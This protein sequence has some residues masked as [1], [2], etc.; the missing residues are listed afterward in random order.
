MFKMTSSLREST[1]ED[2]LAKARSMAPSLGIT[3]VTDTTWLDAIGMPVYASIRPDA[4][5][6]TLCVNAGKGLRPMEAQVG[7]YMEAI[8]FAVAEYRNRNIE[9]IVSTPAD[10]AQQA[11]AAFDYVDLCPVLGYKIAPDAKVVCVVAEDIASGAEL[12]VPAELVFHPF[13]ENDGLRT[14]GTGTNGLCSGNS[15]DEATVH[16]L[17]ELMERD[18]TSFNLF[19]DASVRVRDLDLPSDLAEIAD[20]VRN[21]GLDFVL[22]YTANEFDLP[23]LAGY[24]LEP[25]NTAP[26]AICEGFGLHLAPEIAGVRALAEAAQ[27]RLTYIHGG[28]DDTIDRYNFFA[29][30]DVGSE[31]AATARARAAISSSVDSIDFG[32]IPASPPTSTINDALSVIIDRLAARG[33][34]N[35]LRV[36]LSAEAQALSVVKVLVPGLEHCQPNLKR[37]GPRLARMVKD[38]GVAA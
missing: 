29:A 4:S 35:V 9:V 36:K 2:T 11:G 38:R 30:R 1:L 32:D 16:G 19:D 33:M 15:I 26:V 25:D 7:A 13:N 23:Y 17:C 8:E 3:R 20:K 14:F 27:S 31:L 34:V 5:P 18:V 21:A 28:R 12:L 24:V 22:R 37:V 6:G 10:I